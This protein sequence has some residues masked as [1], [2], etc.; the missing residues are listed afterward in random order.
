MKASTL[1]SN[2]QR[3]DSPVTW[4]KG[5]SDQQVK[6]LIADSSVFLAIGIEVTEFQF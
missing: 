4:I 5:A 6:D 1:P 3:S 2:C